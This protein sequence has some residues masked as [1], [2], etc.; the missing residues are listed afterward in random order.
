MILPDKLYDI[1]KW[2]CMI[3]LPAIATAYSEFG[4]IWELPYIDKIP[5]SITVVCFL[6]GAFLGISNVRYYKNGSIEM[7]TDETEVDNNET[8]DM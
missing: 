4:E 8:G 1:L 3:G 6:L 7:P 5:K 2:M